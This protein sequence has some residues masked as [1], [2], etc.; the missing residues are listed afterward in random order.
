MR[1]AARDGMAIVF[2]SG[3]FEEV[4]SE[5]DRALVMCQGRLMCEIEGDALTSDRLAQAS[6]EDVKAS[7]PMEVVS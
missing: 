1:E 3:D 4:A 2:A 5:A 7:A 6:Y